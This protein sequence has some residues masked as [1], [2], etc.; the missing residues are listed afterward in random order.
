MLL[1]REGKYVNLILNIILSSLNVIGPLKTYI[2]AEDYK[3]DVVLDQLRSLL[4]YYSSLAYKFYPLSMKHI[5]AR[6]KNKMA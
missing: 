4:S 6:D 1:Q 5:T 2:I 3:Q